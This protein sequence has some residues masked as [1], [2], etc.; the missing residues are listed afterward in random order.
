[1]I[2]M[3]LRPASERQSMGGPSVLRKARAAFAGNV[4]LGGRGRGHASAAERYLPVYEALRGRTALRAAVG[5]VRGGGG[6]VG[7]QQGDRGR[8]G[9]EVAPPRRAAPAR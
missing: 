8:T 7:P 2:F 1:M 5:A 6:G 9:L 3:G 4:E